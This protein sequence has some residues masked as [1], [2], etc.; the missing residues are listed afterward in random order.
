MTWI[1]TIPPGGFTGKPDWREGGPPVAARLASVWKAEQTRA[2]CRGFEVPLQWARA[3]VLKGPNQR[4]A[5][6]S[7][8]M[9][10]LRGLPEIRTCDSRI[11]LCPSR[12]RR[13]AYPHVETLQGADAYEQEFQRA[14]TVRDRV[15]MS[16]RFWRWRL[17]GFVL[18]AACQN[19]PDVRTSA[20]VGGTV[21]LDPDTAPIEDAVVL[22]RDGRVTSVG[23]RAST[24]IPGDARV[25]DIT[26]MSVVAGFWNAHVHFM[27]PFWETAP[28]ADADSLSVALQA[29]LLRWGF[30]RVVDTGSSLEHTLALRKRIEHG[31]VVG[32]DILTAGMPF[33]PAEGNPFYVEPLQAPQLTGTAQARQQV[34]DHFRAGAD[35]LKVF[36]GSPTAPGR[37]VI[38]PAEVL[39]AASS[40]AH[41]VGRLVIAH[42]TTNAGITSALRGGVDIL[43]HTTPDG[44]EPWDP[45]LIAE[46]LAADVALI[47]TL[48]LWKW[49]LEQ[50]GASA[51]AATEFAALAQSQ[52]RA[53]NDGGGAILFGTDVGFISE[54][55]PTRE[56]ILLEEAGLSYQD[57]LRSLT[58]APAHRLGVPG[59]GTIQVGQS[60]DFV[61]VEGRPDDDIR[62]LGNVSRVYLRGSLVFVR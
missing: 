3:G 50:Q 16:R 1:D 2:A 14:I 60:A 35:L 20:L 37:T 21:F 47:P 48:T 56:Y 30:V 43:A 4:E 24:P 52:V 10:S 59:T 38:M 57:I 8:A 55:D 15:P 46:M 31:G 23:P 41:S 49:S 33:V 11:E 27:D 19:T 5:S 12:I 22:F 51:E 53:Y 7:T 42:P 18:L 62:S 13:G 40:V 26:G 29:M 17:L 54:Y 61:V 25:T 45:E 9:S 39:D 34:A 44:G 6:S 32:P 36:S 58:T 28:A